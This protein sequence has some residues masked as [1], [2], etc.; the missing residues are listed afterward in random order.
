MKRVIVASKTVE[1]TTHIDPWISDLS[2]DSQK[3]IYDGLNELGVA[4]S[5]VTRVMNGTLSRLN[6]LY[7]DRLHGYVATIG[8]D[9]GDAES[10]PIGDSTEQLIWATSEQRARE[11]IDEQFSN[12]APYVGVSFG[13]LTDTAIRSDIL[14]N[15]IS[16]IM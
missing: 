5:A 15:G 3:Y 6:S 14:S 7:G 8:F 16:E 13:P 9:R 12:Y 4:S 11:L 1:Q 10:G 2:E